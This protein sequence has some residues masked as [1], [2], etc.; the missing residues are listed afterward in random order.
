MRFDFVP[1]L[2]PGEN[3]PWNRVVKMMREQT[4][5]AEQAYSTSVWL[6]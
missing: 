6:K 4:H 1:F 2:N 3:I 5:L